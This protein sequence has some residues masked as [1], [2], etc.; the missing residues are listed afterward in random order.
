ME[1]DIGG[2]VNPERMGCAIL[3]MKTMNAKSY[4]EIGVNMGHSIHYILQSVPTIDEVFAF[5]LCDKSTKPA[6]EVIKKQ[7]PGV[8]FDMVCGNTQTTL[9]ENNNNRKFDVIHIDGGHSFQVCYSDIIKSKKFATPKTLV[10]IDDVGTKSK[11]VWTSEDVN[12]AVEK[13]IGEG[14]IDLYCTW[15]LFQGKCICKI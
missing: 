4:M 13:A 8:K 1:R 14:I 10:I 11:E 15:S 7:Y 2:G 12:R 5:D 9:N 6:W 3:L